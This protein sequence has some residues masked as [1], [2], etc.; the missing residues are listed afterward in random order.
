MRLTKKKAL[1]ITYELW[2]WLAE[3]GSGYK[4]S[5]EG[6]GKYGDMWF[7]CPC[8]EYNN[9]LSSDDEC[10]KCPLLNYWKKFAVRKY[11]LAVCCSHKS[12]YVLWKE[13]SDIN[14]RKKY[15]A[16]IRDAAKAELDRLEAK[17]CSK[18]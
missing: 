8:C 12:P 5:W 17:R 16:M 9:R 11:G 15:A 4:A 10:P 7:Y 14:T 2:S 18:N 1:Q 6:W 3:T 13:A